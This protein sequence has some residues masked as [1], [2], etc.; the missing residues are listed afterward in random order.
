MEVLVVDDEPTSLLLAK[1][2]VGQLGHEV[3]PAASS[4][5]AWDLFQKG[6]I[7][8]VLSDWMM[9]GFDGLELCHKI[10]Q[11]KS[12][13][14]PYFILLTSKSR[15]E[16]VREAMN[17]GVDDFLPKPLNAVDLTVR[18]RVASRIVEFGEE[19]R[20]LKEI[21]PVCMYCRKIR[22][23]D[24]F[25]ER[26]EAYFQKYKETSFSH[27]V[28]PDCYREHVLPQ[29]AALGLEDGEK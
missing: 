11:F 24:N 10:R 2:I 15:S 23:D 5:E 1:T 21:L 9:P 12:P 13:I 29:L 22:A 4:A 6:G 25:W 17:S 8:I 20:L 19:I 27:G 14:Y 26:F 7:H 16:D 28:C 18:I 3:V